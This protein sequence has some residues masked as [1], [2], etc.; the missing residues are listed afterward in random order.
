MH[1]VVDSFQWVQ[2][3]LAKILSVR[4]NREVAPEFIGRILNKRVTMTTAF[5][6]VEAPVVSADVIQR[7]LRQFFDKLNV[8]SNEGLKIESL[9]AVEINTICQA[10]IKHAE[11]ASN[12][13]RG[14]SAEEAFN[15]PASRCCFR[16]VMDFLP[17][18]V[19][20]Q[21]PAL[22]DDRARVRDLILSSSNHM[23]TYAFC[24]VHNRQC[25]WRVGDI[26][27]AGVMCT[28]DSSMGL[29]MGE[30]GKAAETFW[31]WSAAREFFKE[32]MI[33]RERQD[34]LR[35][36]GASL[37]PQLQGHLQCHHRSSKPWLG[38]PAHAQEG[39]LCPRQCR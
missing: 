19:L 4:G 5:S 1:T 2:H 10:E 31:A 35:C 32:P 34:V 28:D 33:V 18:N 29:Q 17:D 24:V 14:M 16:S 25:I 3:A 11:I 27:V 12:M 8:P 13:S 7:A 38:I 26:H 6:G 36:Q 20:Q 39:S 21:L 22:R 15:A 30:A 37:P 9:A 23:K